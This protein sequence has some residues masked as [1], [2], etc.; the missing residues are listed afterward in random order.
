VISGGLV[1]TEARLVD[2]EHQQRYLICEAFDMSSTVQLIV[3]AVV[4]VSLL[5]NG[6]DS[7]MMMGDM[8]PWQLNLGKKD[9]IDTSLPFKLPIGNPDNFPIKIPTDIHAKLPIDSPIN[10]PTDNP[11]NLNLPIDSP[12]NFPSIPSAIESA[13][14]PLSLIQDLIRPWQ[15]N[16]GSC[17]KFFAKQGMCPKSQKGPQMDGSGRFFVPIPKRYSSPFYEGDIVMKPNLIA[18][19]KTRNKGRIKR[20]IARSP[21]LLWPEGKVAYQIHRDLGRHR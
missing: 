8:R 18:A 11:V 2:I 13:L 9:N 15:L 6:V 7:Q 1:D 3:F 16:L 5:E 4:S 19:F 17:P 10:L 20:A 21:K 12:A 14:K